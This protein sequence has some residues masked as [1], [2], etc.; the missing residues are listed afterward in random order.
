MNSA[1]LLI[2]TSNAQRKKPQRGAR[3]IASISLRLLYQA[4]TRCCSRLLV[5]LGNFKTSARSGPD[6]SSTI[7]RSQEKMRRG[8][9]SP[10]PVFQS[11]AESNH[12][13]ATLVERTREDSSH[14]AASAWNYYSH[15]RSNISNQKFHA[16]K[17]HSLSVPRGRRV[18]LHS[19][20][21]TQSEV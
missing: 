16:G 15:R 9:D 10:R 18:H 7:N 2:G 19:R 20:L 21:R 6:T 1:T 5:A 13:V 8:H 17:I 12:V 3:I 4:F 14:L 11:P